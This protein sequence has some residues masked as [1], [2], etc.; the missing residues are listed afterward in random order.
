MENFWMGFIKE[1]VSKTKLVEKAL[2][3]GGHHGAEIAGLSVL[4][5][6]AAHHLLKK[7]DWSEDAKAKAEIAGLGVLA[8]PSAYG[9]YR[10]GKTMAHAFKK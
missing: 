10:T 6:P 2:H 5:A 1:A 7:T 4:G 9:L 3:E 8:V